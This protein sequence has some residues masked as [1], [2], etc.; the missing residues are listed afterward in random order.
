VGGGWGAPGVCLAESGGGGSRQ[1]CG[2]KVRRKNL[3]SGH[4]TH[5]L[6]KGMN[7]TIETKSKPNYS[8]SS[9]P[10]LHLRI[11]IHYLEHPSR[12]SA[13]R[14][15][16]REDCESF[17][18]ESC[19]NSGVYENKESHG[20]TLAVREKRMGGILEEDRSGREGVERR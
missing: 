3:R 2:K 8:G 9:L 6:K 7:D 15:G 13:G 4:G 20:M 1:E 12:G 16:P 10:S 18:M 11:S 19:G 17:E 5:I 14:V